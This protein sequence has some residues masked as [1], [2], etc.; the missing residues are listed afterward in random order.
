MPS[1]EGAIAR[2]AAFFDEGRFKALLADLVAIPSTAQEPEFAPELERYLR[3]AIQ[4]WVERMGFAVAIH[5]NPLEGF[6]PILTAERIEDP[7]LP[8]VLLYGHGDTVRG[9]DAQWRKGLVPWT[10]TEEGDR[11]YGRG[12]ADNKGQH[13][14]NLAAL[15]AVLAERGGR[16]G[17]NV[18]LLL[19]MAEERGSR[20]LQE[21]AEAHKDL[22]A[23]DVLIASDGPRV[24]PDLPTIATGNRGIFQFDLVLALRQGG[25]HSGHWG[26]LTPDPAIRLGHAIAAI[27]DARGRILV[28]DW[29]P[30]NGVPAAVRAALAGCPV[31]GGEGAAAIDPD[32]GEPGLTAAEKIYGWNSFI[33]LAMLSGQPEN[34]MNA[35]AP[36]ARATCHIRYIA[37]T[38]PNGFEAALRRHLD[39]AGFADIAIEKAG[40]RMAAARTAPDH[41][42][43]LWAQESMQRS[44]EARVQVIPNS[45]GG[46][47]GDVFAD[48]LGLPMVW[49]PHSYNGCKQ[50][51]PDEHLLL[52]PARQ[53]IRAFAGLWWDLGEPGTPRR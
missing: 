43:V 21:F 18:K 40:V 20:G 34:P 4:P 39:A 12:T 1:R 16:L 36:W 22:L 37:D 6:G 50:H 38:D 47:P 41:P 49:V 2:A 15:E 52:G 26:G 51:G 5:P 10:L 25:V 53:G 42:W 28:R 32:W 17:C 11:W 35:V 31:G 46:L 30:R 23:A 29:L 24:E 7:A 33:L 44:L 3:Q 14:I 19:E 27:C 13:A 48:Q 8:T 45:S 9:L